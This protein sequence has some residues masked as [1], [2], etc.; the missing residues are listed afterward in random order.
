MAGWWPALPRAARR[1]PWPT[2]VLLYAALFSAGDA[3]QQRLRGGPA[4]WQ[5]T[6]RVA[7]VAVTFHANFN[8]VW[9]RLL[10]RALPGRAPRTVLAKVLCDQAIGG[11][12]AVSAF[13]AERSDVLAFCAADQLRPGSCSLEDRL[14]R[15]LRL[16]VGH[17]P[18]LFTT[19]WRWHVRVGFRLPSRKGGQGT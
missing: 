1:Y 10:E 17:L 14:H 2:N 8:Y 9:L 19:E 7:T 18:L 11:P 15:T 16:S 13:Y 3:L 6:R 4:D 5:Q 12:V